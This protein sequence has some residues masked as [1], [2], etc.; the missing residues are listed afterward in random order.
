MLTSLVANPLASFC[1]IA[2]TSIY[3]NLFS[4]QQ[5]SFCILT[6]VQI[7]QTSNFLHFYLLLPI[8][9]TSTAL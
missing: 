1:G 3:T 6:L 8:L 5:D 2:S 7:S 9:A 4:L